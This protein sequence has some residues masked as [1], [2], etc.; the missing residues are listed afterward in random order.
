MGLKVGEVKL[1]SYNPEWK[2]RFENEKENLKKK[3][4]SIALTIE[5]IGST[6]IEGLTA[7]PIIDIAVGVN[8]LEDFEKVR[9]DFLKDENY[10]VKEDSQD[11]EILIRKGPESN[12]THFIHVMEIDGN[13]YIESILFRDYLI[14]NPIVSK[15][16]EILKKELARLY[17]N[18]RVKYTSSK[19]EFIAKI[20]LKAKEEI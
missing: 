12:R 5:H 11:D 7:K 16:Y 18:E 17:P 13:R 20:L 4:G 2:K 3:M 6:S 19:N 14:S 9:A 8:N 15:D 10:S 1:E